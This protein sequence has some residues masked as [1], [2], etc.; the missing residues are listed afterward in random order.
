MEKAIEYSPEILDILTERYNI[1]TTEAEVIAND[2]IYDYLY[3]LIWSKKDGLK[4]LLFNTLDLDYGTYKSEFQQVLIPTWQNLC[5]INNEQ[6]FFTINGQNGDIKIA[7]YGIKRNL[8][9]E[10]FEDIKEKTENIVTGVLDVLSWL[11]K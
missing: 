11:K 1:G 10:K 9:R 6:Y 8:Q 7:G 4:A 2:M 5:E 3:E